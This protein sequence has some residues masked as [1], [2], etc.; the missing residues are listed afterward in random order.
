MPIK[1]HKKPPFYRSFYHWLLFVFIF[2]S[3]TATGEPFL[4]GLSVHQQLG[5]D[6]FIAAVY[7][8]YLTNSPDELFQTNQHR[9]ME[10]RVLRKLTPRRFARMWVEGV[11]I[12]N[13]ASQLT[14]EAENMVTFN[15]LFIKSLL[16]GDQVVIDA[17]INAPITISLNGITLGNVESTGLFN[18]LLRT[19]VGSVPLSTTFKENLLKAGSTNGDVLQRFRSIEPSSARTADINSWLSPNE[20]EADKEA[21]E[22]PAQ[23]ASANVE[24]V[25]VPTPVA[26][27]PPKVAQTPVKPKAK[28]A[29]KPKPKPKQVIALVTEDELEEDFLE[30]GDEEFEAL[31]VESLLSRQLYQSKLLKW[32]YKYLKYPRRAMSKEEEGSVQVQIIIDRGGNILTAKN[33]SESQ[34]RS[35]NKEALRAVKAANPFPPMPKEM[36]GERYDF[37]LPIVFRLPD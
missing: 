26:V 25:S 10:L 1:S 33:I 18:I 11:S 30:D 8:E 7:A 23:I 12:N 29:P 27:A 20:E 36:Q 35:L 2:L 4:N 31:T 22:K 28:P 32:A 34:Y 17:P 3:H 13:S 37:T 5:K 6:H 16:P 19:W 14:A 9:R 21:S 15:N 24:P